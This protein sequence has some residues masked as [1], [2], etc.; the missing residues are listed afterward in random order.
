MLDVTVGE[1]KKFEQL[2]DDIWILGRLIKRDVVRWIESEHKFN[3]STD[4]VLMK[5][6]QK[7]RGATDENDQRAIRTELNSYQFSFTFKV[8]ESKKF[9]G[10]TVKT[11]TSIHL[12]FKNT[13][14][15]FEP[16]K[17]AQLYLGAGGQEGKTGERMDIDSIMGNYVAMQ[18]QSQK[19]QKTRK[20]Y[21]QVTKVRELTTEEMIKAKSN[22]VEIDRIEKALK[23]A[24]HTSLGSTEPGVPLTQRPAI[25]G[26]RAEDIPF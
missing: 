20:V 21:Q 2:P 14:G 1:V 11:R 3:T 13:E 22:E 5:L 18:V 17:L 19:N 6:M 23:E 12:C 16:N 9:A 10:Y 8:L 25:E 15:E 7:L 4:E 24:E 26:Q